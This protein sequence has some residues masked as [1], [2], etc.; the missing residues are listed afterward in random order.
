LFGVLCIVILCI[1][2]AIIG[3]MGLFNN[4]NIADTYWYNQTKSVFREENRKEIIHF[5]DEKWVSLYWTKGGIERY[6]YQRKG[7]VFVI[8]YQGKDYTLSN[9]SK[10][11]SIK[12][13]NVPFGLIE[14]GKIN[15]N[16]HVSELNTQNFTSTISSPEGRYFP[17]SESYK[18]IGKEQADA[19]IKRLK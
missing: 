2:V 12:S 5:E 1:V 18:E 15:K 16:K 10:I 11:Y 13:T 14:R 17:F 7:D 8:F 19:I 4:N 9:Y 3:N 6:E